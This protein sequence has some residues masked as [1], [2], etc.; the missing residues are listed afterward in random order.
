MTGHDITISHSGVWRVL[1]R[2]GLNRLPASQRH[3][4]HD[5]RWKCY[6]Q[7]AARP[8][9]PA[10]PGPGPR[11]P[12]R[13]P[14]GGASPRSVGLHLDP[15]THAMALC[16]YEKSEVQ[17]LERTQPVRPVP[18]GRVERGTYD[19]V[20]HGTTTLFAA[21]EVTTGQVTDAYHPAIATASS[22]TSSS[23]WPRLPA[24]PVACRAR[25]LRHPQARQGPGLAS[26]HGT[27]DADQSLAKLKR[28]TTSAMGH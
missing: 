24:P 23:W 26:Q 25:Q 7:A 10:S 15:S 28:Q 4:R 22:R 16:V 13:P 19:Y 14:V 1:K 20:R 9:R 6:E 27:K 8:P 18:P 2:L 17:A 3:K 21:L 12:H 5:R 11:V